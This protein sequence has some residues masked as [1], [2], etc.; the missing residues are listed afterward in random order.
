M[1]EPRTNK[2]IKMAKIFSAP[3]E[4]KLPET[5]FQNVSEWQKLESKYIA[6]LKEHLQSLGYK[7]KYTGE[8]IRFPAADGYAQY[9]V[10]ST[11]PV[12]LIHLE[13]GDAWCFQYAE[14]LT[15]KDIKDKIDNE[16]V[17]REFLKNSK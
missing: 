6:D 17:F 16:K 3:K 14:R 13:L 8:V 12:M 15:A 7:D 1:L 2:L 5:T 11:K 9:M 4:V 10:A